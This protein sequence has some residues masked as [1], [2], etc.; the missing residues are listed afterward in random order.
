MCVF[1]RAY[2]C[3]CLHLCTCVSVCACVSTCSPM[4]VCVCVSVFLRTLC[5]YTC[6]RMC[7]C[8]R[9]RLCHYLRPTCVILSDENGISHE[10]F[11]MSSA[12]LVSIAETSEG[13]RDCTHNPHTQRHTQRQYLST[14]GAIVCVS[15]MH[16]N[17]PS[18]DTNRKDNASLCLFTTATYASV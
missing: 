2:V 3:I 6:V 16:H 18:L 5:L 1:A 10:S 4:C 7:V 14:M 11:S 9:V 13:V 17:G 15:V 12:T 8:V